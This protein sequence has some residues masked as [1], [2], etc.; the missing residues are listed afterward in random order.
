MSKTC[1]TEERLDS[2]LA[3]L[4]QRAAKLEALT[5]E[6]KRL[7]EALRESQEV[8]HRIFESV[9]DSTPVND[10]DGI[11]RCKPNSK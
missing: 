4:R 6:Y 9:T 3:G 5:T 10:L 2:E 7:E 1:Q 8:L 11:T